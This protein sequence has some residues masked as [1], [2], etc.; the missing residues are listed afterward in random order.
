MYFPDSEAPLRSHDDYLEANPELGFHGP[1]LFTQLSTFSGPQMFVF[2]EMHTLA[3]GVSSELL[4]LLT[5]DLSFTNNRFYYTH[6]DGNL[7]VEQYPFFIPR[8]RL[9][10]IGQ[11][12][13]DSRA[14]IPVCFDGSFQNIIG[15]TRGTRAVD[16]LDFA[17]VSDLQRQAH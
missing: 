6:Q 5:V 3:R 7:E 15:D 11:A 10:R 1:S 4:Q 12:I 13:E 14:T 2:D 9:H 8:A 17:L 16:Y